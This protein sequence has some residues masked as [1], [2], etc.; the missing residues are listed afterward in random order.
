MQVCNSVSRIKEAQELRIF[1]T[2]ILRR[3][4]GP[5]TGEEIGGYRYIIMR[6]F[7]TFTPQ[8]ISNNG[9]RVG[10]GMWHA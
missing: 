2:T 9:H 10:Q 3:K 7:M 4:F 6:R 8:L 1:G 5:K